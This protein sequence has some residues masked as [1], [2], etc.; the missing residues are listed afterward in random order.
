MLSRHP[1]APSYHTP[2]FTRGRV[3]RSRRVVLIKDGLLV[4]RAARQK[5][6]PRKASA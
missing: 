1:T 4:P 6:V 2:S 5:R 3:A